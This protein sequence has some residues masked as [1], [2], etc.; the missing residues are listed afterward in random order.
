MFVGLGVDGDG[1]DTQL[2]ARADDP[3]GDFAAIGN[4]DLVEHAISLGWRGAPPPRPVTL[5]VAPTS[6]ASRYLLSQ[7]AGWGPTPTALLISTCQATL[8]ANSRSP[9]C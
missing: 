3:E 1:L 6:R 2:A 4:Q 7:S 9:N 5:S 8:I